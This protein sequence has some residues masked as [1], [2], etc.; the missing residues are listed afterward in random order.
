MRCMIQ[1]SYR[2]EGKGYSKMNKKRVLSFIALVLVLATLF[3]AFASYASAAT[4][5]A[6]VELQVTKTTYLSSKKSTAAKYRIMKLT[7]GTIVTQI[8]KGSYYLVSIGGKQGYVRKNCLTSSFGYGKVGT[9]KIDGTKVDYKVAIGKDNEFYSNHDSSGRKKSSGAIYID[10]RALD[11]DRRANLIIYGHNMRN[12]T[13]FASLHK[14]ED[15]D[16]FAKNN[17]VTLTL[18]GN[19]GLTKGTTTY[20]IFAQGEFPVEGTLNP[21]RTQFKNSNEVRTHI[22]QIWQYCK[23]NGYNVSATCPNATELITLSTCVYPRSTKVRYLVFAV[24]G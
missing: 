13:M 20:T 24:K 23:D 17:K 8:S 1:S 12:G 19:M 16:F 9:I 14:Y 7:K 22:Q 3:A 4:Q 18:D 15:A 21:W 10:F 5:S 2:M 11:E 6:G